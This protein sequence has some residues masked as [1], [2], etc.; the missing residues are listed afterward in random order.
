ML[1]GTNVKCRI[2]YDI[3]GIHMY[4][5][6]LNLCLSSGYAL[7]LVPSTHRKLSNTMT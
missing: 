3:H 5:H 2:G 7:Y 4:K 6:A 1:L